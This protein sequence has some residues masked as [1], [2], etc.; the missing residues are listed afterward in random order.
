MSRSESSQNIGFVC[1]VLVSV[2]LA[3][4]FDGDDSTVVPIIDQ[5]VVPRLAGCVWKPLVAKGEISSVLSSP[6]MW[7]AFTP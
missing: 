5:F 3:S 4:V 6:A 7:D 2:S 1:I